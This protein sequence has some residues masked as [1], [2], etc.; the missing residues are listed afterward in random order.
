M[1]HV[2]PIV[3]LIALAGCATAPAPHYYTLDMRPSGKAVPPCTL[4]VE[5]LRESEA[6]GRREILIQRTP[7]EV[8]YYAVDQWTAALG[9]LVSQ[10][11]QSELGCASDGARPEYSLTGTILDFGQVDLADGLE[12]YVRLDIEFRLPNTSRYSEPLF[13]KIYSARMRAEGEDAGAVVLALSRCLEQI[14]AEIAA[15]A[16]SVKP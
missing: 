12:A 5:R 7:T 4:S 15:D 10:K 2:F 16:A 6:L 11:L 8:E 13:K 1:K 9:E 3:L 14:A